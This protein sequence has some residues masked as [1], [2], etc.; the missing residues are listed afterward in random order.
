MKPMTIQEIYDYAKLSTLAYVD[1]SEHGQNDITPKIIV[2]E[3]SKTE[4]PGN[5]ERIPEALGR[6]MFDPSKQADVTGRWT[7]LDPYFK[8][9]DDTGHSD[10]A[11]GF[12]AMLV[13]NAAYGK[14]LAIAGTE[15]QAPWQKFY[16]L[17]DADV[18]QIGFWGAALGLS[19]NGQINGTTDPVHFGYS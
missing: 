7:I 12:A 16:D 9:S 14:V 1:L 18:R 8:R 17:A 3:G 5:S 4:N 2:E 10:P 13:H 11:S 19:L 6:Q 15:P